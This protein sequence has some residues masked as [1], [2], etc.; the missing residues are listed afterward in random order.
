MNQ[1][2]YW[3]KVSRTKSRNEKY[4]WEE[5][6]IRGPIQIDLRPNNYRSGK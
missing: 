1:R 3:G 6:E 4:V 2:R 5:G